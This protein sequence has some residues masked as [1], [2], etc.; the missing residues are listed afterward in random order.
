MAKPREA[1]LGIAVGRKGVGKTYETL[2]MIQ[3]YLRGNPK[4][5]AKPRKVLI[6]DVNNEFSDVKND[7]NPAFEHI[8]AIRVEDIERW[9]RHPL[10]EA[11]RVSILKEGG[12]KKTLDEFAGDL[13]LICN[14]FKNG[15]LLIE[16]INKFVTDAIPGD[17]IGA[18]ITVRHDSVDI[19]TH[20]QSIG[21]AA[22][23]KIWANCNWLRMHACDDFV[24]RHASKFGGEVTHLYIMEKMVARQYKS[25]NKRF[26][27][28]LDKD[29]GT[30]KGSFNL[31][32]F[33][34]A[35]HDYLED[36]IKIV[37]HE[38]A[39]TDLITGKKKHP[40]PLAAVQFLEKEYIRDYYGNPN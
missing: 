4:T 22:H 8:K 16:D 11:R 27:C 6:L 3:G 25:G 28:Y 1:L 39:R 30:I 17:I 29:D 13:Q 40:S 20:F 32:I 7:Q 19:V 23:P 14:T 24:V 34:Q 15:L 2:R 33:K 9:V 37:K 5:G 12:G 35:I 26:F 21:K 36:N 10:I 18:M 38:T 31:Q